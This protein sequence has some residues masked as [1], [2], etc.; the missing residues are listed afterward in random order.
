MHAALSD[1]DYTR[2]LVIAIVGFWLPGALIW[3]ILGWRALSGLRRERNLIR[4]IAEAE[5]AE[6]YPPPD[7]PTTDQPPAVKR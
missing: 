6:G 1:E 4:R 3:L 2:T 5:A 7:P